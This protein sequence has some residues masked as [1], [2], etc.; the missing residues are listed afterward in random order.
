MSLGEREEGRD[1]F[2]G[3]VVDEGTDCPSFFEPVA[4]P[5]LAWANALEGA[6]LI[7]FAAG[8]GAAVDGV[9]Y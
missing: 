8:H 6:A 2:V 1:L 4:L 7:V 5:E 9:D 3:D